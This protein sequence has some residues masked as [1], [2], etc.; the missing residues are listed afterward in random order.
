MI[1]SL[2]THVRRNSTPS[3]PRPTTLPALAT[4]LTA[5]SAEGWTVV[6]IVPT[7]TRDR[8][9][10]SSRDRHRRGRR[11]ATA[12]DGLADPAVR[13][14]RRPYAATAP[15]SA[16]ASRPAGASHPA[17]DVVAG[18]CA[19]QRSR[20]PPSGARRPPADPSSGYERGVAAVERDAAPA[21]AALRPPARVPAG[22]YADPAGRFELRYWDG[23]TWTEHVSRAGQQ[24]TDPPVA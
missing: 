4:K 8:R 19:D 24:F 1:H 14:R 10:S 12:V 23:S 21:A 15:R 17:G 11:A 2:L 20:R 13:A 3:P 18:R 5:K 6:A 22:W 7:G 16:S 9:V